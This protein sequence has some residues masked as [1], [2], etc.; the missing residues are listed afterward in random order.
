MKKQAKQQR[1]RIEQ[2]L[3]AYTDGV[4]ITFCTTRPK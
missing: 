1:P 3:I 4:N 2:G